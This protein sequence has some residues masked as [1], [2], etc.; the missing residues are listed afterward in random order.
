MHS[1]SL[2]TAFAT[3]ISA[4]PQFFPGGPGFGYP[5]GYPGFGYPGGYPGFGNAPGDV[6][7]HQLPANTFG[8]GNVFNKN[9]VRP[10]QEGQFWVNWNDLDVEGVT[11]LRIGQFP[12]AF[13]T[14]AVE[15]TRE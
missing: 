5:G 13:A 8:S 1:L 6:Y 14:A 10:G 7:A 11:F 3:V 2:F 4:A 12:F 15:T 9:E